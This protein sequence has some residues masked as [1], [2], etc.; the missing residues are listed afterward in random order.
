[1]GKL[2]LRLSRE[3]SPTMA[4]GTLV[5]MDSVDIGMWTAD[6]PGPGHERGT[7]GVRTEAAWHQ[8]RNT[9]HATDPYGTH[10]PIP[11]LALALWT[12]KN[13]PRFNVHAAACFS[14]ICVFGSAIGVAVPAVTFQSASRKKLE[15]IPQFASVYEEYS[16]DATLIVEVIKGLDAGSTS[17]SRCLRYPTQN[18]LLSFMFKGH[19]MSQERVTK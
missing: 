9:I 11:H 15:N 16:R 5:G 17:R 10:I 7:L 3:Q 2:G 12:T 19:W 6:A 13:R 1:M 14:P 18:L 8:D 4:V